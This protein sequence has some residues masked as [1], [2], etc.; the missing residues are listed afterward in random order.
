M[1]EGCKPETQ[2]WHLVSS[3]DLSPQCKMCGRVY[4][5]RCL[6]SLYH[7]GSKSVYG[8]LRDCGAL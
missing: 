4:N 7:I 1:N 6:E 5:S 2:F 3:M 8:L